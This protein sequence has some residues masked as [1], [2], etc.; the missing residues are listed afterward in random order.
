MDKNDSERL[1]KIAQTTQNK[2]ATDNAIVAMA[3]TL[4]CVKVAANRN[5]FVK[6]LLHFLQISR[7]PQICLKTNH[8]FKKPMNR[9][10]QGCI[11]CMEILSTFHTRVSY[12]N[13]LKNAIQT[14]GRKVLIHS[15]PFMGC[16]PHPHLIH[17]SLD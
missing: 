2:R 3:M 12:K 5:F 10:F 16:G 15:L 8:I 6:S 1:A 13:T 11:F 9:R 7:E 14:N 4:I 17:P